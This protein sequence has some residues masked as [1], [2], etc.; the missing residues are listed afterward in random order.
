M[1]EAAYSKEMSQVREHRGDKL[2]P[3]GLIIE[4]SISQFS[5]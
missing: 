4:F 2:W 5:L 3:N 1:G